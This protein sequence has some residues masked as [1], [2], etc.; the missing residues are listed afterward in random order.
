M[1]NPENNE[2]LEFDLIDAASL[3]RMAGLIW[4]NFWLIAIST[5]LAGMVA[6]IF[7]RLQA[8][9]YQARTQVLVSRP[10]M[11]N[12][13]ID[14]TQSMNSLQITQTYVEMLNLASVR[15]AAAA[16][17]NTTV[18]AGQVQISALSNTQMID[19]RIEDTIPER[20]AAIADALVD[21]LIE[22]NE[23]IQSG[24]YTTSEENLTKQI[25]EMELQISSLQEQTRERS[26][27]MLA[28]QKISLEAQLSDLKNQ[29]ST[30]QTEIAALPS[31]EANQRRSE[32]EQLQ[33]LQRSYEASYTALV[34]QKKPVTNDDEELTQLEKKSTLYQQI[35]LNLLNS[36][37]A[38]RLARLQ[39]TLNVA[40]IDAAQIDPQPV[41][42]RV[43]LN[44]VLGAIAGLILAVSLIF[45]RDFLDDTLKSREDIK[46][47]FGLGTLGLIP[48]HEPDAN[49]GL[50]V[51]EQPR[52]PVTEAYRAL[53]TN[54][55][56]SAVDH[57][58]K[59]I[60][61]TSAGPGEG[62]TTLA[63]NLAG[64][65]A[66]SGKKVLL[67]DT[68]LRR[69]KVHQYLGLSN[70]FGLTDLFLKQGSLADVTQVYEGP[71]NTC[72]GV[73]T[74]GA[75]P[76]NPGELLSSERM[77]AILAKAAESAGIVIIDSAP[78]LVADSQ[79]L[80]ASVDGIL[81]VIETGETRAEPVR[82]T[83]ES[84]KRAQA[85]ILG[86]VLNRLQAHHGVYNG[87][88]QSGYYYHGYGEEDP[89]AVKK[90][91][92]RL[93]WNKS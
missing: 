21:V 11:Q 31:E 54:L 75:I 59:T 50:F 43:A 67:I 27:A 5:L 56:F 62:K 85:H 83:L 64:V 70:R 66:Q 52:S 58:L 3:R 2:T 87:Y 19:I 37:E 69:P 73:I 80:S 61:I 16:R 1:D 28:E 68:D 44:T 39:N 15:E 41:R 88:Y 90:S 6:F 79:A 14:I 72:F 55:E 47:L 7:S 42:P 65:L 86:L 81:I 22:K 48:D 26:S 18:S 89:T 17:L 76:P 63:T 91:R 35:Y 30:L 36:R 84:F 92:L 12:Q 9:V 8:P 46:R 82:A 25:D 78:S 33:A 4:R 60:L 34:V 51:A 10:S 45:V 74:T 20:A 53:R 13:F 93:P 77:R 71:N 38:L 49:D 23:E 29:I 40:K 32:L 57:P 24:R